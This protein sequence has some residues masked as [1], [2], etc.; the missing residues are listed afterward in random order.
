MAQPPK[1]GLVRGHDKPIHGSCAI[2]FP[3]GINISSKVTPNIFQTS[4]LF[5]GKLP[6]VT[7]SW[8]PW[9]WC[10]TITRSSWKVEKFRIP[11]LRSSIYIYIITNYK[12]I[13][14]IPCKPK[15]QEL[16]GFAVELGLITNII[17]SSHWNH[18]PESTGSS[19]LTRNS[20]RTL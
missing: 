10:S 1:D 9:S 4:S 20:F 6:E 14:H 13:I 15:S 19:C 7:P 11:K 17:P 3:G 2:Y 5:I 8:C 18:Q 16:V 12:Y